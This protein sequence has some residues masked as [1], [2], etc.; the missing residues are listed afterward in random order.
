MRQA[1]VG[2]N[3]VQLGRKY[4]PNN[5]EKVNNKSGQGKQHHT[6]RFSTEKNV[7]FACGYNG[8]FRR[9]PNYPARDKDLTNAKV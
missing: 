1:A 8:H 4:T 3:R 2:I 7:C 9:D 6:S 5:N